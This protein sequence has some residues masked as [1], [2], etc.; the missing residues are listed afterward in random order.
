VVE[1][2]GR[3]VSRIPILANGLPGEKEII[4]TMDAMPDGV[5]L[6]P[7]GRLYICCYEPSLIYRWSEHNGLEL[8]VHDKDA[9]TLCHPTSCAFRGDDLFVANLGRW[10]ITRIANVLRYP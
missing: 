5:T 10:H 9:T 6:D 8:L 4:I 7:F 3:S 2:F 1:T